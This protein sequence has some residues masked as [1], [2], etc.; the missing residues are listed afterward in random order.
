MR[1]LGRK[2][3]SVTFRGAS[4][5]NLLLAFILIQLI[6]R[7]AGKSG[8]CYFSYPQNDVLILYFKPSNINTMWESE[9]ENLLMQCSS[10]FQDFCTDD[11]LFDS[12]K[13]LVNQY[14]I[15]SKLFLQWKQWKV[16]FLKNKRAELPN[17][18]I[19]F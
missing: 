19:E 12:K 10:T 17:E 11:I 7:P 5:L 14:K 9:A 6:P 16:Y 1:L 15:C 18:K 4:S 2:Q 3:R 8:L 13:I